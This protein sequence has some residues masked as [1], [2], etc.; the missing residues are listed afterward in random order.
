[1]SFIKQLGV[2]VLLGG[3]AVGGHLGWTAYIAADA[4]SAPGRTGGRDAPAVETARAGYRDIEAVVEAVGS[5]RARRAVEITPLATGRVIEL[6]FTAGDRVAAG[7]VLLRLDD[8]IQR[9]DLV[10]AEARLTEARADL[11]RGRSLKNSSAVAASAVDKQIATLATAQADL[12][13]AARR[14]RD[15]TVTA[16]FDG[17]V[18]FSRVELGA[19]VEEG[20]TVTTLDDLSLVEV[21]FSVQ[22]S[23]YG[24]IGPGQHIIAD[25]AAFPGRRF[26]GT[27]TTIDSRI[28]PIGRAVQARALIAN[29]DLALPAGMFMH[30][31]VVLER[32]HALT[33]PEEAVVVDADRAFV[34]VI[35]GDGE[36]ARAQRRDVTLG[37]RSFGHVEIAAG[38]EANEDVVVRG[39]QRVRDGAAVRR[40]EQTPGDAA[41]GPSE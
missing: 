20:D 2:L 37:Q 15:R 33:V 40:V 1:M 29:P 4:A 36:D 23:L 3:L 24:Q 31:S 39:V 32:R 26:E 10:E 16:P 28:D 38:V 12:D 8:D 25:A 6:G 17:I 18:G 30:I 21:Q 41:P 27:I 34:F 22:E 13:R 5:T 19:R 7:S 11:E 35:V 14:L 9:A